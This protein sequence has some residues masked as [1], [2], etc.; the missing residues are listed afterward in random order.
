MSN[1]I[2]IAGNE[3]IAVM[4]KQY[5]QLLRTKRY[6][7]LRD[8][9]ARAKKIDNKEQVKIIVSEMNEMQ[10]SYN[11]TWE[12]CQKAMVKI[13]RR[14][15]LNSVFAL[16]KTEDVWRSVGK[17]LLRCTDVDRMQSSEPPRACPGE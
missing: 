1:I 8:M 6:R 2:R 3:L 5:E 17:C 12:Y 14:Y 10:K 7:R 11:L 16:S 9:Y 4:K 13:N 15:Q